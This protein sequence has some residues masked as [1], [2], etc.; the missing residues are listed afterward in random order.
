[1]SKTQEKEKKVKTNLIMHPDLFEAV[2]AIA[3]S[4]DMT[5]TQVIEK[6]IKKYLSDPEFHKEVNLHLK[7]VQEARKKVMKKFGFS[8]YT[9]IGMIER[10]L[11]GHHVEED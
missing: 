11:S 3:K 1:M 8:K 2:K 6:A 7:E 10:D 4:S 5:M 9:A